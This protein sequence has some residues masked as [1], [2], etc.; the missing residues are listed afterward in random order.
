MFKD[1]SSFNQNING[2]HILMEY[3][4]CYYYE[5]NVCGATVFD[6]DIGSWTTSNVTTMENMF[7]GAS[8]FQSRYRRLD[9][10]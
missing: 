8:A 10:I 6:Q 4:K 2:I 7:N 5:R 9:Y 3:I 1:A